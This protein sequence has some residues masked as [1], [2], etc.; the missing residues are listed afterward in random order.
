MKFQA[1]KLY[2]HN[3]FFFRNKHIYSSSTDHNIT[4]EVTVE[5]EQHR[6]T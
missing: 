6:S 2:K 3:Y 5:G 1:I 4:T